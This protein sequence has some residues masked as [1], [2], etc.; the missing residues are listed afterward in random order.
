MG[1]Y[2]APTWDYLTH[3]GLNPTGA[4][5][6]MGNL[7]QESSIDPNTPGGGLAQW[8][9]SRYRALQQYAASRGLSVNSL[10]A[11]LGYLMQE[12][13]AGG[14]GVTVD[15]LNNEPSPEAGALDFS[16][17]FERPAAWAANNPRREREARNFYN[18][19]SG[20]SAGGSYIQGTGDMSGLVQT[21]TAKAP[22][23]TANAFSTDN[24]PIIQ[25]DKDLQ[26]VDFKLTNPIQSITQDAGAILF[27][28]ALVFIGL[29]LI[30]F[31]L[32]AVVEKAGV[33]VAV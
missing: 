16:N 17:N 31:G 7:E 19:F 8:G 6:V 21:S 26:L 10:T 32:V 13:R 5:A 18:Q 1:Q 25:I 28:T 14:D 9:G 2:D 29:I 30:I 15:S 12:I 3:N 27:R 22:D 20:G 4:A 11:Q 24:D 23:P 33:Q